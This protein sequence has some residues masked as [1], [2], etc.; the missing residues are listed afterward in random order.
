MEYQ[1]LTDTLA[2]KGS[3]PHASVIQIAKSELVPQ[4]NKSQIQVLIISIGKRF[5][6]PTHNLEAD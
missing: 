1:L 6:E 4:L 2:D 3:V 5:S